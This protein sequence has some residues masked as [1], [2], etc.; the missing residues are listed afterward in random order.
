MIASSKERTPR[1]SP[2]HPSWRSLSARFAASS[3]AS[4]R[5]LAWLTPASLLLAAVVW[6][7]RPAIVPEMVRAPVDLRLMTAS[8]I[9]WTPAAGKGRARQIASSGPPSRR[10]R[11][12]YLPALAAIS[13]LRDTP[14]RPHPA[15]SFQRGAQLD[16]PDIHLGGTMYAYI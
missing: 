11:T 15:S 3:S 6:M 13:A 16:A 9:A 10:A 7:R 12:F 4:A 1:R 5:R 8:G 14:A 2:C